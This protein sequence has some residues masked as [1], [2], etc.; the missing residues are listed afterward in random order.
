MVM[1]FMLIGTAITLAVMGFAQTSMRADQK[2]T[3]HNRDLATERDALEYVMAVVRDDLSLGTAGKTET[4]TVAGVT[5]SCVGLASSGVPSGAGRTDRLVDCAT[6][7][8]SV[9]VRFFDR[10]GARAGVIEEILRNEI[11]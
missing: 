9:R 10:S 7:S 5:A 8:L 2:V 11:R 6:D 3:R 1:V 4:V